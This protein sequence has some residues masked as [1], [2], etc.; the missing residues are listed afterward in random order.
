[1]Q[2]NVTV[3]D[4]HRGA[5]HSPRR[6]TRMNLS[7]SRQ[8]P[9]KLVTSQTTSY[10][11]R[12]VRTVQALLEET[13]DLSAQDLPVVDRQPGCHARVSGGGDWAHPLFPHCELVSKGSQDFGLCQL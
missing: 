3:L 5:I 9:K 10:D 7:L 2:A 8:P 13:H 12:A 11:G 1:M 6:E 4:D